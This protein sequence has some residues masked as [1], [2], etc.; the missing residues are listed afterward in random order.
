MR[1]FKEVDFIIQS[2]FHSMKRINKILAKEQLE[3]IEVINNKLKTNFT[4]STSIFEI[5]N[6]LSEEWNKIGIRTKQ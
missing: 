3:Q 2:G 5:L 1:Y 6:T 4:T